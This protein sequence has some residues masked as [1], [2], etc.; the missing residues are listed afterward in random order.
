MF[1]LFNFKILTDTEFSTISKSLS[2]LI[3]KVNT[4]QIDNDIL[5]AELELNNNPKKVYYNTKYPSTNISYKRTDFDIDNKIDVRLF[6]QP[7]DFNL[8]IIIGSSDD[9]RALKSLLWVIKNIT[10][11]TDKKQYGLDEYWMF[12]YQT[13]LNKKGDCE[14]GSLLLASIMIK[15]KIPEWKVRVTTGDVDDSQGNKGGHCWV[16]YYCESEDKWVILDWCYWVSKVPIKDRKNYKEETNYKSCWFSFN[17]LFS[18]AKD[19]KD[20]PKY[21]GVSNKK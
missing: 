19:T 5:N 3:I 7:N 16:S 10:Y 1:N 20:I 8:P 9:D 6:V 13:L 4:L 11:I 17:N 15:N 18:W 21:E 2:D 12:P 14:D